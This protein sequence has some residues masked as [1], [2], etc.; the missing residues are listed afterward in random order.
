MDQGGAPHPS[1][2]SAALAGCRCRLPGRRRP[3][4]SK[5]RCSAQAQ[6][7]CWHRLWGCR[8][9]LRRHWR[10]RQRRGAAALRCGPP[11]PGLPSA[12]AGSRLSAGKDERR[13]WTALDRHNHYTN[14]AMHEFS[15][16]RKLSAQPPRAWLSRYSILLLFLFLGPAAAT[17]RMYASTSF[18]RSAS[19][20]SRCSRTLQAA[21][22]RAGIAGRA[23]QGRLD[24]RLTAPLWVQQ[25]LLPG[26]CKP[27]RGRV[28]AG[29]TAAAPLLAPRFPQP[30]MQR[31]HP[32]ISR[33]PGCV[34]LLLLQKRREA[35]V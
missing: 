28:Q 5:T 15:S 18:P 29:R 30:L 25:L 4:G 17:R 2:P 8:R 32:R 23:G 19:M 10:C 13:W 7:C 14:T 9:Q 27:A 16:T 33:Y 20:R 31:Q 1:H 11:Q 21:H 6:Q 35:C 3:A 26:G 12:G 22:L 24:G 34:S